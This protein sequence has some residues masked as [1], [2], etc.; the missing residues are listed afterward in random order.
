M[1]DVCTVCIV[2]YAVGV[3]HI[4]ISFHRVEGSVVSVLVAHVNEVQ[5]H[6]HWDHAQVVSVHCGVDVEGERLIDR[7]FEKLTNELV[8]MLLSTLVKTRS[9][10]LWLL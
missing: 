6:G 3:N 7:V 2:Q 5:V 8:E 1:H 4:D 10:I 9:L